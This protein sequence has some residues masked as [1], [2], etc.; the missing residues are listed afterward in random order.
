MIRSPITRL[1]APLAVA[2]LV[3]ACGGAAPATPTAAPPTTPPATVAPPTAAPT[4]EATAAATIGSTGAPSVKA[5]AQVAVGQKFDVDW[6][7]PNEEGDYVTIV[8]A[9]ATKWTNEPYF[10]T[11]SNPTPGSLTAP[12]TAGTYEIW[13]VKGADSSVLAKATLTV[14]AF[15]GT[16]DAADSVPAGQE[17]DVSW[18]GPNGQGDYVTIVKA[19]ATAWSN[20]PYFYTTVGPKGTLL[21]PIDA[22]SYEL[23]YVTGTGA[24]IQL[25]RPITVTPASASVDG[26]GQVAK[27]A[28]VTIAWTGPSGP[29]DYITIA[30]A[31]SPEG[32]YLNYCY[33][34]VASPCIVNAPDSAGAYEVRYVTGAQGRTLA[35]EALLVK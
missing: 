8:N 11:Q 15:V 32:T 3:A 30:A 9:G 2:V 14:A 23:W 20:E 33:T 19:G 21:A 22:G 35:T 6:T 31:G 17:F 13:Y 26:P 27:G 34:T 29:G 1:S 5:P 7:G 16:L 28:P 4:T 12:G 10:Y 25:R 18:T 24:V